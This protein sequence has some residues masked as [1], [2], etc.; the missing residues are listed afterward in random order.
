MKK[1]FLPQLVIICE[2]VTQPTGARDRHG[3]RSNYPYSWQTNPG[4][5]DQILETVIYQEH[6]PGESGTAIPSSGL[7]MMCCPC[8]ILSPRFKRLFIACKKAGVNVRI[9]IKNDHGVTNNHR[10]GYDGTTTQVR[11]PFHSCRL[12]FVR[13]PLRQPALQIPLSDPCNDPQQCE[14]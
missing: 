1:E 10:Q 7:L 9:G 11:R 13:T 12:P 3:N 4:S 2:A 14:R 6:S 8:T 5:P